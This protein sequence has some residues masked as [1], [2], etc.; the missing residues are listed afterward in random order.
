[1]IQ[2]CVWCHTDPP[3]KPGQAEV[4]DYD[5]DRAVIK[6]THPTN[7]GGSP[8]TNYIVEKKMQQGPWEQVRHYVISWSVYWSVSSA[9]VG[10][11]I[12][13]VH[14]RHLMIKSAWV[15]ARSGEFRMASEQGH[16]L[17]LEFVHFDA[18]QR[19]K[20]SHFSFSSTVVFEVHRQ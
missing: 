5:K 18:F 15:W 20:T 1:M 4:V 17:M 8:I 9:R 19:S 14:D 6:W 7:D 13:C 10:V 16:H 12:V 3:S 11:R 2:A